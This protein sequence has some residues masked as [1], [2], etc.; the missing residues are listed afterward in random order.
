MTS[1][2]FTFR[3][4]AKEEHR[5][6]VLQRVRDMPGVSKADRL[7]P[8]ATKPALRR[9]AYAQIDDKAVVKQVIDAIRKTKGV[10]SA[11]LPAER[12]LNSDN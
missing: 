2:F 4:D 6:Q 12:G 3:E 9:L 5:D 8:D 11:E 1:V 10:E 7:K